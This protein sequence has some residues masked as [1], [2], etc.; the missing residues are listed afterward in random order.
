ME[1]YHKGRFFNMAH[2]ENL[3]EFSILQILHLKLS[4]AYTFLHFLCN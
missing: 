3:V 1:R 4:F 2:S